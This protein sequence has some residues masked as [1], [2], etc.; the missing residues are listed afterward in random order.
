MACHMG[1]TPQPKSLF[2]G[3]QTLILLQVP[4]PLCCDRRQKGK[5]SPLLTPA[6]RWG[7]VTLIFLL[8]QIRA[9]FHLVLSGPQ[10]LV[11]NALVLMHSVALS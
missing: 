2:L 5:V 8:A 3:G 1:S 11:E 9:R 6:E 4:G 7:N 10:C